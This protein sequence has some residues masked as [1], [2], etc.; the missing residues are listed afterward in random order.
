MQRVHWLWEQPTKKCYS[1]FLN[2]VSRVA[3]FNRCKSQFTIHQFYAFIA[4]EIPIVILYEH[5]YYS[6]DSLEIT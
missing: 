3:V 4:D 6:T 2:Y 1:R 5:I